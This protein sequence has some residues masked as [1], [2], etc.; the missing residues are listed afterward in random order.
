MAANPGGFD[1]DRLK[2]SL[3][4]EGAAPRTESPPVTVDQCASLLKRANE[5]F[6]PYLA[7]MG[8]SVETYMHLVAAGEEVLAAPALAAWLNRMH[9]DMTPDTMTDRATVDHLQACIDTVLSEGVP[10]DLIETGAWKGGL[11][12][13]MR[14]VLQARGVV[15]RRVWV[16][17]SFSG[18][19]RPDYRSPIADS[20]FFFLTEPLDRL[21]IQQSHTEAT[22]RKYGLLDEQVRFLPGMFA[23]TLPSA[24]I[25]RLAVLRLDGDWYDSTKCAL[26]ALYPRLSPGGFVEIDDYGMPL[27]CRQ[28]VDQYRR[29]HGIDEP[30]Q[31]VNHQVVFWR[32]PRTAGGDAD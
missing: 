16:A 9:P 28:A 2:A 22:F 3:L 19:P 29:N 13:L 14:G 25:E 7:P 11:T 26:E 30:M 21:W 17:D 1:L 23:D 12:V 6:R 10:G 8:H 32:K 20:L 4:G 15:D 24:P 5:A 27:G 18:L 31:W